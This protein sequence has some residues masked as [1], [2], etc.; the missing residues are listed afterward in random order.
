MSPS[1]KVIPLDAY[2][3]LATERQGDD[4]LNAEWDRMRSLAD[5][6]WSWRDPEALAALGDC[7]AR[8]GMRT[9]ADWGYTRNG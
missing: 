1:S 8:L 3:R 4:A 6:A 2:R 9:L 5:D 7:V